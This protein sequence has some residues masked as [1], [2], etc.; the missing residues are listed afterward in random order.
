MQQRQNLA[1][2]GISRQHPADQARL[3]VNNSK[4]NGFADQ[5]AIA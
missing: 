4:R 2:K 3:G 5:D 1:R